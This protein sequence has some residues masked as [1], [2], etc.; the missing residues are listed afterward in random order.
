MTVFAF[1]SGDADNP[2]AGLSADEVARLPFGALELAADGKILAYNDTEPDETGESRP[3]VVGR[4]FFADVARWAGGSMVA[5]EFRKGVAA[6]SLNVVFDCAI[7][8]LAYKVRLHL[9]VSPI[10]GT[11][12]LFIK[13]LRRAAAAT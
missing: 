5:G 11:Y 1:E 6:G 12:W 13:R 10:L 2:L 4:D 3:S 7:A 9:K 8:S